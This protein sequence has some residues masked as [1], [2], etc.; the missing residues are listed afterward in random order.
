[1]TTPKNEGR[2][3]NQPS[4]LSSSARSHNNNSPNDTLGS[5]DGDSATVQVASSSSSTS[6]AVSSTL[7]ETNI[8]NNKNNKSNIYGTRRPSRR[9]TRQKIASA[10]A[11]ANT[12]NATAAPP[13]PAAPTA[14]TSTNKSN[15]EFQPA[16]I[17]L[18]N[19][20]RLESWNHATDWDEM[21]GMFRNSGS[22]SNASQTSLYHVLDELEE[23]DGK[24][25]HDDDDDDDEDDDDCWSPNG[26]N[27]GEFGLLSD[28][29]NGSQ[30]SLHKMLFDNDQKSHSHGGGFNNND[31]SLGSI[32]TNNAVGDNNNNNNNNSD[33]STGN[34]MDGSA[35]SA[36]NVN[37]DT[38]SRSMD[39]QATAGQTTTTAM[40]QSGTAS[41]ATPSSS[42]IRRTS[43]RRIRS[44]RGS[45]ESGGGALSRSFRRSV[46]T[47]LERDEEQHCF[48]NNG[49]LG[50]GDLTSSFTSNTDN[51]MS[52]LE[53][54]LMLLGDLLLDDSNRS[55]SGQKSKGLAK[56]RET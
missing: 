11:T 46:Q 18:D 40:G 38:S 54:K 13:K 37:M 5:A 34:I 44:R 48:K 24:L 42:Q 26:S 10:T 19:G 23:E 47:T 36:S 32:T 51:S 55:N 41:V 3:Q 2:N 17:I 39:T 28:L 52:D 9:S 27:N 45:Q 20:P 22:L 15:L 7:N 31:A 35:R 56:N 50:G 33:N 49:I 4:S 29:P 25:C 14:A 30:R 6:M 8:N 21:G 53:Q 16:K 12:N 43:S 1:M